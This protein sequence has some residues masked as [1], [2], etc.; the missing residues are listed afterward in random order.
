MEFSIKL[1]TFKPERSIVHIEGYN[2]PKKVLYLYLRLD[3]VLANSANP[4]EMQ[5]YAVFHLGLRCL[6]KYLFRCFQSLEGK[7]QLNSN[8]VVRY[9][10]E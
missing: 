9:C 4:D 7:N 3:F 2:F 1:E 5:H 8:A 6:Q 10:D